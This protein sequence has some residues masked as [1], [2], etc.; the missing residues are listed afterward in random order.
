LTTE[1]F[2]THASGWAI[3]ALFKYLPALR[4]RFDLLH[5]L[6]KRLIIIAI[7]LIVS[8]AVFLLQRGGM[9]LCPSMGC[10]GEDLANFLDIALTVAIHSQRRVLAPASAWRKTLP[11]RKPG[12]A[13]ATTNARNRK[14]KHSRPGPVSTPRHSALAVCRLDAVLK[15]RPAGRIAMLRITTR[16][17]IEFISSSKRPRKPS[18]PPQPL[19]IG[20]DPPGRCSARRSSSR[21]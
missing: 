8:L 19:R 18:H 10:L 3:S 2:L 9:A 15:G 11:S 12:L 7:S 21:R 17:V 5:G 6:G 4:A 14:V 16:R 20:G 13:M 1:Q